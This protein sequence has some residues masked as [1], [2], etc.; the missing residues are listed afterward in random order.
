MLEDYSASVHDVV[1]RLWNELQIDHI[2]AQ[3]ARTLARTHSRIRPH[4]RTQTQ[5]R[6]PG[7]LLARKLIFTHACKLS[8][9]KHVHASL[10]LDSTTAERDHPH[11]R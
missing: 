8:H 10:Q 1:T 3:V 7:L 6:C 4:T 9:G 11:P 5:H 2:A